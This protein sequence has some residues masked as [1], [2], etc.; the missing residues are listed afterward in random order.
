[1]ASPSFALPEAAS[2]RRSALAA[3]AARVSIPPG[4]AIRKRGRGRAGATGERGP[5]ASILRRAGLPPVRTL[6]DR[7]GQRPH[8]GGQ[9]AAAGRSRLE[10]NDAL[11]P[12][13]AVA[14]ER[15]S[16]GPRGQVVSGD[17]SG[18]WSLRLISVRRICS[19]RHHLSGSR[20]VA[21]GQDQ[22]S[23]RPDHS[24]SAARDERHACRAGALP[25]ARHE[26]RA[27]AVALRRLLPVM[28]HD[29][30]GCPLHRFGP[31]AQRSVGAVTRRIPLLDGIACRPGGASAQPAAQLIRGAGPYS[32]PNTACGT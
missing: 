19:K 3:S 31:Q 28:T 23:E 16:S 18:D 27:P 4:A 1:M 15:W 13:P 25:S 24:I 29:H 22:E 14:D 26:A 21:P 12:R 5:P 7:P 17:R 2:E 6:R 10:R 8:S 11:P 32:W 20:G 9:V 30:G